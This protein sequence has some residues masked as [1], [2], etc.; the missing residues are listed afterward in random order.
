MSSSPLLADIQGLV[1]SANNTLPAGVVM[2]AAISAT[3]AAE[4]VSA[5]S[6]TPTTHIFLNALGIEVGM[7]GRVIPGISYTR[8]LFHRV[9]ITGFGG[10]VADPDGVETFVSISGYRMLNDFIYAGIGFSAIFD[11]G[12]SVYI[13][14]ANPSIGLMARIT[15]EISFYAEG[16]AWI[17]KIRTNN[18]VMTVPDDNILTFKVGVKYFFSWEDPL[19][20][21]NEIIK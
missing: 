9:F 16:T 15:P 8:Y 2:P 20:D 4:P 7:V 10:L 21:M 14:V 6:G 18:S 5:T 1:D 13:G 11:K 3:A 12:R 17:F 19:P